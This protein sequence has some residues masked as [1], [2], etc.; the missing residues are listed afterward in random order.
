MAYIRFGSIWTAKL[1][2]WNN[3][4]FSDVLSSTCTDRQTPLG[5]YEYFI[6]NTIRIKHNIVF[7]ACVSNYFHTLVAQLVCTLSQHRYET[8][9]RN[10]KTRIHRHR[11]YCITKQSN[12]SILNKP[13]VINT[14]TAV[15]RGLKYSLF[16]F[17][18]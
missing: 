5:T 8:M 18:I 3:F 17:K 2:W 16:Q 10:Q 12:I 6:T 4:I 11:I 9:I 14:P 1:T 13:M 15:V 7:Q